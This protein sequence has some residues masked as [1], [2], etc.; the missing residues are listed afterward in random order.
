[1][2]VISVG[3][4][5][6]IVPVLNKVGAQEMDMDS[7]VEVADAIESVVVHLEGLDA[8]LREIKTKKLNDEDERT[9]LI[10]EF[11]KQEREIPNL[12]FRSFPF[13]RLS[14]NDV[15]VLRN[16]GLYSKTPKSKDVSE[17]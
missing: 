16:A 2:Q 6:N 1:M 14:P 4:I 8:E 7:A 3:S 12:D 9:A 5:Y 11:A 13:L 10:E 15:L 17:Q